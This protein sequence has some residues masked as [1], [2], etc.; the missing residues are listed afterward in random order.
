MN[1]GS[2]RMSLRLARRDA[3]RRLWRTV[4]VMVLVALPVA[5]LVIGTSVLRTDW[6]SGET[7]AEWQLGQADAQIGVSA[8][9]DAPMP[10]L[11][12]LAA[13]LPQGSRL[14][15]V[16]RDQD[17]VRDR[18]GEGYFVPIEDT[19]LADPITEGRRVLRAGRAPSGPVEIAVSPEVLRVT[20]R[21]VGDSIRLT[22]IAK[23]QRS[24]A[25][26]SIRRHSARRSSCSACPSR[27]RHVRWRCSSTC[28]RV[29]P[30][31]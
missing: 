11:E 23:T 6:V 1:L 7:S 3:R 12:E 15:P 21:H 26:S 29:R 5:G 17:V 19:P 28:L 14:V 18:H 2:W 4:L 25:R 22:R 31:W 16:S 10:S 20:G 30:P 13:T 24:R 27:L 8:S 9:P